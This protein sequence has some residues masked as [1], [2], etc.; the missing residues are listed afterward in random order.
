VNYTNPT[1]LCTAGAAQLLTVVVNPIPTPVITGPSP[2]VCESVTGTTV[3]YSTPN[4][5]GNTYVWI[6]VGGT[7][8]TGQGTNL[9]TVTWTTPGA[10]SVQVTEAIPSSS[11]SAV[12]NLAVTV[13]PKPVTTPITHN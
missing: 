6:V 1:T 8:V 4:V 12:A 10:G 13:N 7:I 3:T 2:T 9:I 11:C 5:V